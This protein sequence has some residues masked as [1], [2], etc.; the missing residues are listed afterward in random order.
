MTQASSNHKPIKRQVVAVAVVIV[1][2]VVVKTVFVLLL[3]TS[4]TLTM[5]LW[6]TLECRGINN[7]LS[8]FGGSL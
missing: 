8:Y 4:T 1:I 2:V 6:G 5:T 7:Y 3:V